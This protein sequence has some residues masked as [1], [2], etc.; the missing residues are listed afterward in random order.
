MTLTAGYTW[1]MNITLATLNLEVSNVGRSKRF[2]I[3]VLKMKEDTTRSHPPTFAYLESAGCAVTMTTP[4]DGGVIQPSHSIELGFETEDISA[5]RMALE[6]AGI[7]DA[8]PQTMGW[9]EAVEL[10]DPDGN[11]IIVYQLKR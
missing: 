8:R 10:R 5:F 6:S 4:P 9:G 7:S 11:R 2:Y 1:H 3:D